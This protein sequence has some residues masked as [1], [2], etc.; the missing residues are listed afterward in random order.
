MARNYT[1][2]SKSPYGAPILV[3]DKKDGKLHMCIYYHTLNKITIKKNTPTWINDLFDF[4]NGAYYVNWMNFK[5]GYYQIHITY[6]NVEKMT[7]KTK[8]GSYEFLPI[9]WTWIFIIS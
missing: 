3:V 9:S 2:S 8:C 7:M 4:L 5:F 1:K 6:V